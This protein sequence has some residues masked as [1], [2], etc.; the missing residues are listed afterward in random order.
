MSRPGLIL[1]A[2]AGAGER[3]KTAGWSQPKYAIEI[4]GRSLLYWSVIGLAHLAPLWEFRFV[5]SDATSDG[6]D[7]DTDIAGA[8]G[9]LDLEWTSVRLPVKTKGQAE[10]VWLGVDEMDGHRPL[11]V[12]NVD[13]Y[14]QPGSLEL[15][16]PGTHAVYCVKEV[17]D[18]PFS[19][20]AVDRTGRAV[21]VA[22]KRKISNLA[23]IGLYQFSRVDTYRR[24]FGASQD[25][26]GAELYVAPLYNELLE[27]GV[28]VP[29]LDSSS[30][31]ILGTPEQALAWPGPNRWDQ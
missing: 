9:D 26:G 18:G 27:Q 29:V 22:E 12:W 5:W 7:V 10:T 8:L 24:V 2:M 19:W 30:V 17:R 31:H 4:H 11:L 15:E 23:S 16:P 20:V 13:T 25:T 1:V 3:F 14:I 6:R 21:E 28:R